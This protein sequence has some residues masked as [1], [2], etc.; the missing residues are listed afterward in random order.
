MK[1]VERARAAASRENETVRGARRAAAS[2]R[3]A[4]W[5]SG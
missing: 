1:N 3:V 5:K 2:H 4:S